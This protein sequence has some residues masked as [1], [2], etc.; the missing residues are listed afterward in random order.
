[1]TLR[2][3]RPGPN[4]PA[5]T[6]TE[7]LV[8]MGII[9]LLMSLLMAAVQKVRDSGKR[10]ENF[11]RMA[12]VSTAVGLA[13]QKNNMPYLWAGPFTLK[14]KYV[15]DGTVPEPEL[16]ILLQMFPNMN[17]LRSQGL[18]AAQAAQGQD[19]GYTGPDVTLD[20]NQALVLLLTGGSVTQ[21]TGFSN[22]PKRPFGTGG[23]AR[24]GP[25]LEANPS[26][27]ATITKTNRPNPSGHPWL[28]DSFG[29]PY[30][31][32]AAVKGKA[33]NY[34][35]NSNGNGTQSLFGV[36]PY[37]NGG[38]YVNESGFQLISAGRDRAFGP[39]P[40]LPATGPGEDDQ[41][42]FSQAALG[43]GIK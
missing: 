23:S 43:S 38:K 10:T 32:F 3:R 13:K 5:F 34:G 19:N 2:P 7:L 29:E 31:V 6:L 9:A 14:G 11:D 17:T 4:R 1:M 24:K 18:T 25:Y 33:G 35:V 42:N 40:N 16:D 39:G 30:A 8:V 22:D 21:F 37:Q 20:A 27:Y 36:Q 12:Q 26:I 15:G 28:I 41:A